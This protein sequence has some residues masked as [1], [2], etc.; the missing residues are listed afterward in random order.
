MKC[1]VILAI[2]L[3]TQE[4]SSNKLIMGW[5]KREPDDQYLTTFTERTET[6]ATPQDLLRVDINRNLTGLYFTQIMLTTPDSFINATIG[7]TLDRTFLDAKVFGVDLRSLQVDAK[8]YGYRYEPG[9][10][11]P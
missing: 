10:I 1:L 9:P 2:L 11:Y 7:V 5:G 4:A 6:F 3:A 8:V